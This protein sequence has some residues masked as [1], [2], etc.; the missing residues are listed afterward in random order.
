MDPS[1]IFKHENGTHLP[2]AKCQYLVLTSIDSVDLLLKEMRTLAL[3]DPANSTNI[4]DLLLNVPSPTKPLAF[5]HKKG[6]FD[7]DCNSSSDTYVSD[8]E[9]GGNPHQTSF[10]RNFEAS[11]ASASDLATNFWINSPHGTL[12]PH[13]IAD[14]ESNSMDAAP[15]TTALPA[16][17]IMKP[18]GT[19]STSPKKSVA[20]PEQK[21]LETLHHYSPTSEQ[22]PSP[23]VE[24]A[25]GIAHLWSEMDK[26]DQVI[27]SAG[28]SPPPVPPPHTSSTITGLLAPQENDNEAENDEVD[29]SVLSAYRLSHTNYSN[30]S[31][32]EKLDIFLSNNSHAANDD[33]DDHLEKLDLAKKEE[34]DLNIH[35]LS[36]Q[37]EEPHEKIENPLNVLHRTQEVRLRSAG[38]SQSSL[39]SLMD[40][41]RQLDFNNI[42]TLSTGIQLNDGI[43]GFPDSIADLIIPTTDV[44]DSEHDSSHDVLTFSARKTPKV[45][46]DSEE[47][48]QDS[49]DQSYHITEK[50]I[51]NL[52]NSTSQLNLPSAD[53]QESRKV[54]TSREDFTPENAP[55]ELEVKL[56]PEVFQEGSKQ[57]STPADLDQLL[58]LQLQPPNI[59]VKI[60]PKEVLMKTEPED[61]LGMQDSD[62]VAKF[63][64]KE[65]P[66]EDV[67]KEESEVEYDHQIKEEENE[68]ILKM[69]P[70]ISFSADEDLPVVKTEIDSKFNESPAG[71]VKSES[72][73]LE[74][75]PSPKLT[76]PET[77]EDSKDIDI[78][79]SED[80]DSNDSEGIHNREDV[81]NLMEA[82]KTIP[83]IK[84]EDDTKALDEP[85][86]TDPS[87]NHLVQNPF[88]A[89]THSDGS[90]SG[91]EISDST[92]IHVVRADV[93][94]VSSTEARLVSSSLPSPKSVEALMKSQE[95]DYSN[96]G[97]IDEDTGNLIRVKLET[98][99]HS[100]NVIPNAAQS[101]ESSS[102]SEIF[103]DTSEVLLGMTLAPSKSEDL[104]HNLFQLKSTLHNER[105]VPD[106]QPVATIA[107]HPR[108]DS[109]THE[110]EIDNS[111][112]ANSSNIL[113]PLH[114]MPP[115][116][117]SVSRFLDP[118]STFE[119]SLSAEHD[120]EKKNNTD[121]I[122]IWHS[123][124]QMR[125][126]ELP[127]AP[128][129][130]Q[131]PDIQNYNTSDLAMGKRYKIPTTLT[132]TKFKEVNVVS[133]RVVS[134]GFDDFQ[135]SGFLPEISQTSGLEEHF[136][137]LMHSQSIQP[138]LSASSSFYK[139]QRAG[140]ETH[141]LLSQIDHSR[142][143]E[144]PAPGPLPRRN[145]SARNTLRPVSVNTQ[146][147]PRSK[148]E[149]RSKFHV[150]SFEIKRS[151]SRL[152]PKNFYNDIFEDTAISRPT[153]KASGMKTLPSMDREDVKRILQM[154]QAMSQEEYSNLKLVG[155]RKRSVVQEP[156][157]KYDNIQ[158]LASVHCA[159]LT[160][161][162]M[163]QVTKK[164]LQLSH[165]IG[166]LLS[167]PVAI[168]SKDQ[169]L[170]DLSIFQIKA[171]KTVDPP[172]AAEVISTPI[173]DN[174]E[175][176][177]RLEQLNFPEPDPELIS[178]IDSSP[179]IIH[180]NKGKPAAKEE[181]QKVT[182][183]NRADAV[184]VESTIEYHGLLHPQRRPS[185]P[186]LAPGF[187]IAEGVG[188][189]FDT[190]LSDPMEIPEGSIHESVTRL[191]QESEPKTQTIDMGASFPV[192]SPGKI[193][194]VKAVAAT[195]QKS[196]PKQSPIKINSSPVRLV[197]SGDAVT[198]I[199]LDA[200]PPKLRKEFGDNEITNEKI[201]VQRPKHE[202]GL[203]TVSVPSNVTDDTLLSGKN[204]QDR[205]ISNSQGSSAPL[206]I[207]TDRG[208]LFLRV[209]GL[210]NISLPDI[211][212][213]KGSFSVTLDNGVHCIKTPNYKLDSLNV[214]IG[215]EFELAVGKSLEF[216][217]TMKATYN[218]PKGTLMEVHERKV[219]RS[220]NRISRLFGSKDI[221][222]TTRY[223]P[224]EVQDAWKN[225]F[226]ADGSFARCYIDL[227]QYE[228]QITG[229]ARNF[230]I[231]CFNEWE[232][233]AAGGKVTQR[234][235]YQIAQ[236]EVKMLFV[237]RT[238]PYEVLPTSIKTA[239]ESLDELRFESH[240][241]L[242]GYMHQDGGDCETWKKRWF[243]L[244]G[245]SLIA[246]SEYSHK[247]R[248]KINLA[249]VVEVI[250][251]D[252][253]NMNR[254]SSN[255]RNFSDILLVQ[256]A[257]KIRF[258]NGEI[259]DFGAANKNE[260]M[261]WIRSIQEI[262]YRNKFRRQPWIKLMQE[263]NGNSRPRSLVIG[264]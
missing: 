204:S 69:E 168:E 68:G 115:P 31:L 21:N 42:A 105:V 46:S 251:V 15:T 91:L 234:Q 163:S 11:Q 235:P 140:L 151:N 92:T 147:I 148:T 170:N 156:A 189:I 169:I 184:P 1:D 199:V 220:K 221:I 77:D 171:D 10:E 192:K 109:I 188:E 158:Q 58:A 241:S 17:S 111:V 83:K 200:K 212:S 161:S 219:V 35:H 86:N 185:L 137:S 149:K 101:A 167:M 24:M 67:A 18:L 30:I 145:H 139:V 106:V 88:A 183:S 9:A 253:E 175:N 237:P 238:E 44:H 191:T 74:A 187:E 63:R 62:L 216:I 43:K 85:P 172:K 121:F 34:T 210:K 66:N 38:S 123:Q 152:S 8:H 178:I 155:P 81:R 76:N 180:D 120:K 262:V 203:S 71:V 231:T 64:V 134:P 223:V 230:N 37:L 177:R 213:R 3:E 13:I 52:L 95:I 233:T 247:T 16:K 202:P 39:Q 117:A 211:K 6:N 222:T 142:V 41:N 53:T 36:F 243:K 102:G 159:S 19:P 207:E 257:F 232:T 59:H 116:S 26:D 249:K 239:Y 125:K 162:A 153:I 124:L 259:I 164:Q 110:E 4:S 78:N 12:E 209:V 80:N 179:Q 55:E 174:F 25:P 113:P 20:F 226:A 108:V 28:A 146:D 94:Y 45:G 144:P 261:Q 90:S 186:Q 182:L 141:N 114:L 40:S 99:H 246:H 197:K 173:P 260:K 127:S 206:S 176:V 96:D 214:L 201:R 160:S 136:K 165:V 7:R 72:P 103:E 157:D 196:T 84:G 128:L 205:V 224:Q 132:L 47:V 263:K 2:V 166:E 104:S 98:I 228:L 82:S 73:A 150:P 240:L 27:D 112:L 264:N 48:F 256:N 87:D 56:E 14:S 227:E 75:P 254:S 133:K 32:N 215:K 135:I 60:E 242:E 154:K 248:A 33:L 195:P 250:Y 54:Q 225:K 107:A 218:K 236:L 245:T 126:H 97:D 244:S 181:M 57:E 65:E 190:P 93:A 89:L 23:T 129:S 50:S 100:A 255:Y 208:R 22:E 119:E 79:N 229:I 61:A 49:F 258:A 193:H 194:V 138:D 198:G 70:Q 122:S 29:I 143:E 131:V 217:L 118:A 5:A 51:L 130:Y 252:K